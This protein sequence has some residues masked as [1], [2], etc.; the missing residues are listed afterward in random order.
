MLQ[1][2]V[3]AVRLNQAKQLET[4]RLKKYL[5]Q[6]CGIEQGGESF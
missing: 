4:N 5:S 3:G 2:P 6:F 1:E